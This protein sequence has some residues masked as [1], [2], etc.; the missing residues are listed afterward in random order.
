MPEEFQ[1]LDARDTEQFGVVQLKHMDTD[2]FR[3]MPAS[4]RLV[5]FAILPFVGR[6]SREAWPKVS[7]LEQI[8]GFSRGTVHRALSDLS[9][10]KFIHIGKRQLSPARRINL[11]T[12]LDP[13]K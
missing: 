12:L 10:K 1:V 7:R 5:Y 8:T 11:Y 4:A 3:S 6:Y 2:A 13:P 9:R